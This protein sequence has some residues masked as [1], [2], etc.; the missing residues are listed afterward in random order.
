MKRRHLLL[1]ALS[2]IITICMC[3][4]LAAC[5]GCND[6]EPTALT[7]PVVTIETDGTAKWNAVEHASGYAYKISDGEEKT[8]QDLSVKLTDGQSIV[9]KAVGDGENFTDSAYSEAKTYTATAPQPT[10]LSTPVV[11]INANGLASWEAIPNALSYTTK[12]NGTESQTNDLAKQLADGDTIQVKANGNGTTY[13]DSDFSA[14]K[15]YNASAPQ[16]AQLDTPIV[17]IDEDGMARWEAVENAVGYKY[18]KNTD[19]EVEITTTSVQLAD[20]DKIKVMAVGDGTNYTDS[21]YSEEKTYTAGTVTP[22]PEALTTPVVVI[23]TNGKASWAAITNAVKYV[24]VIDDGAEQETHET[25]VMLTDKQTIKVKAVGDGT[26]H[27][28]SAFSTPKT[29]EQG[30]IT[31][32][33]NKLMAPAIVLNDDGLAT[34]KAIDHAVK[35]IYKIDNG[36]EKETT[37][38]SVQL[39]SGEKLHVKAVGD[40]ENYLDSDFSAPRT[41]IASKLASS[42]SFAEEAN[43]ESQDADSQVWKQNGITFTNLKAKSTTNVSGNFNPVRLYTNSSILIEF[44]GMV[45]IVFHCNSASYATA[46][47]S[48]FVR[49]NVAH[50]IDSTDSKTVIAKFNVATDSFDIEALSAQVRID[51]IDI[52]VERIAVPLTAP[53]VTID[54]D[55]NATWE[56]VENALGY[57]YV[58]N[59]GEPV[60]IT[61]TRVALL[62][63]NAT[64]K[65]CAVGDGIDHANSAYSETKTYTWT[66]QKLGAP[67]IE[68]NKAGVVR[69]DAV[70]HAV[71]YKYVIT[72]DGVAGEE[73]ETEALEITLQDGQSIKVKAVGERRYTDSDYC[74][75]QTYNKPTETSPLKKPEVTISRDGTV[76]V[77]QDNASSFVYKIDGGEETGLGVE[78]V[79]LT[80]GQSITVKAIGDGVVYTDSEYSDAVTY[81]APAT[82]GVSEKVTFTAEGTTAGKLIVTW[83]E[84][85]N[86]KGYM[87]VVNDDEPVATQDN[88]VTLD[89]A[90]TDTFKVM[91]VGDK[92]DEIIANGDYS[93]LF[94][95]GAYTEVA[96][97]LI[98]NEKVYTVAEMVKIAVYYDKTADNKPTTE[99][100]FKVTGVASSNTAYS[101]QYNNIDIT[102]KEGDATFKIYRAT[103]ADGVGSTAAVA[104]EY[105]NYT[106]TATGVPMVY[107]TTIEF[108]AGCEVT[109]IELSDADRVKYAAEKLSNNLAPTET[110]IE[111]D[112]YT[113]T[114]ATEGLY[115]TIITWEFA[116]LG[117]DDMY[118]DG[119]LMVARPAADTA[120]LKFTATATVSYGEGDNKIEQTL[121]AIELTV[122]AQVGEGQTDPVPFDQVIDFKTKFSSYAS[123]W[124]NSYALKTLNFTDLGTVQS[125]VVGTVTLSN[126]SKQTG[127]ITDIPTLAA[128]KA[129]QY[130]T[131]DLTSGGTISK[132]EF[133]LR[134]WGTK[135]LAGIQIEYTTD[136]T[137]W[138]SCSEK[139]TT[140]ATL[141]SSPLPAGVTKVRLTFIGS[142][143]SNTQMGIEAITLTINP[144]IAG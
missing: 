95:D 38:L 75:E 93:A 121:T 52:Y 32:Q 7:T 40:G 134:Q 66:E 98:D 88:T 91:A 90:E 79:K 23:D 135:T 96:N 114:F 33:P 80:N 54:A 86:A 26:N 136:G 62:P 8:T 94:N 70:E 71:G 37:E 39:K 138:T 53:V 11:T 87:Y 51:S 85:A 81:K 84:V 68:I 126:V 139:I 55:G 18:V 59:D 12:I 58:I 36:D 48:S 103:F 27:T 128:K 101:S 133:T 140:P 64:I 137:T 6:T 60:E 116:G 13:S 3:F 69:W 122:K 92:N 67:V 49:P 57:K 104:N 42:L 83:D 19:S 118:E 14:V 102:L 50:A 117:D 113:Y 72:T 111:T 41:Y 132:V 5:D 97:C 25:F 17:T 108:D 61:E 99:R 77:K 125:D 10:K 22:E 31:P 120:D 15:T 119:T 141:T 24:Y 89:L 56:A 47:N 1:V 20:G 4:G 109:A 143:T 65:V 28:D 110:K 29:Y 35:Y 2:L 115:G 131:V 30:T 74:E 73:L 16:P 44:K 100:V 142:S 130:V 127:T 45:K 106:V 112:N 107:G 82:L 34:W 63:N 105:V 43:R 76:N 78:G 46:L 129:N 124:S 21:E 9:V 144:S 123:S